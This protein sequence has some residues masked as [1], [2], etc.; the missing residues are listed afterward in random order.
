MIR[1]IHNRKIW[2][3]LSGLLVLGSVVLILTVGLSLGIDFT[4]GSLLEIRL[5]DTQENIS[6]IESSISKAITNLP[7]VKIQSSGEAQYFIRTR[8]LTEAEHQLALSSFEEFG[9]VDELRFESIGPTLGTE[10]KD[11]AITALIVASLVIVAYIAWSFRKV[12]VPVQSWKY[13][14][15]AIIALIHD[16]LIVTGV[17]TVFTL[18]T[19][20]QVD[21]LFVTA[22]LVV[23]GYSVNDT[24][25]VYDRIR[26]NVLAQKIRHFEELVNHSV[27][28]TISRSINT[29][30]TTLLVLLTLFFYGGASIKG[31]ILALIIGILIGTYSS[32]FLASPLLVVWERI[33]KREKILS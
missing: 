20:Y 6:Q 26:E 23:L 29:S 32:I 15:G 14:L 33:G 27:N 17:Y 10:L 4:G 31:F 12:S 7:E 8:E 28:Q 25:V 22:L 19:D 2:F 21:A 5:A 24:I 18:F 16:V 9:R 30:L 1:I 11:K 13:G 3:S